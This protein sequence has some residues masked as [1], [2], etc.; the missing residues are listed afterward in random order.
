MFEITPTGPDSD[1]NFL[2]NKM[3]FLDLVQLVDTFITQIEVVKPA[4][5]NTVA[6]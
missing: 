4:S 1:V 6:K 3:L 5:S 2:N